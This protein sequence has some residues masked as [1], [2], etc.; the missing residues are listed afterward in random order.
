VDGDQYVSVITQF[1]RRLLI[2]KRKISEKPFNASYKGTIIFHEDAYICPA[3]EPN[4]GSGQGQG[5]VKGDVLELLSGSN[6][7]YLHFRR[8][9]VTG[10]VQS[11]ILTNEQFNTWKGEGVLSDSNVRF[12]R[13]LVKKIKKLTSLTTTCGKQREEVNQEALKADLELKVEPPKLLGVLGAVSSA[14]GLNLDLS[15][16]GSLENTTSLKSEYGEKGIQLEFSKLDLIVFDQQARVEGDKDAPYNEKGTDETLLI[17][18]KISCKGE[19]V[20]G[21]PVVIKEVNVKVGDS[22]VTSKSFQTFYPGITLP[23]QGGQLSDTAAPYKV[24]AR[25]GKLPY[26][27]SITGPQ[28]YSRIFH[29]WTSDD[30]DYSTAAVLMSMFNVTCADRT[31]NRGSNNLKECAQ[32]LSE[33]GN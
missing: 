16:G 21:T 17:T 15:V 13:I 33:V 18:A 11:G 20:T 25:N 30:L 31:D 8:T 4:C 7:A 12:P 24:Y 29:L 28:S 2:P 23:E 10:E 19:G 14:L 6:D 27:T 3:A 26:M 5:V 1:G 32:F 9:D 22:L